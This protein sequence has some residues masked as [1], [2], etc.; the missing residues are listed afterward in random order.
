MGRDAE[1]PELAIRDRIR[2]GAID[3]PPREKLQSF[4]KS[5]F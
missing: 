3:R 1:W 2:I 4:G 5:F